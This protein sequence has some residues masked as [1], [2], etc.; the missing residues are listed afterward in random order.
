M[1]ARSTL[2]TDAANRVATAYRST[3]S[4]LRLAGYA[5]AGVATLTS[6][7]PAA[8]NPISLASTMDGESFISEDAATG[9]FGQINRG[10]GTLGGTTSQTDGDI[11]AWYLLSDFNNPNASPAGSQIDM[12]PREADFIVGDIAFDQS[13]VTGSGVE[14]VQITGID[15]SEFWSSDPNRVNSVGGSPATLITDISDRALGLVW[16]DLQGSLTFGGLDAGDTV[17]FTDGLLTSIDL[18]ITAQFNIDTSGFGGPGLTAWDGSFSIVGDQISYQILDTENLGFFASTI[19]ADIT[20]TVN[21]VGTYLIPE[22]A[23][24]ALLAAGLG[25]CLIRRRR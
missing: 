2:T 12:F 10:D 22:P 16:F 20:G 5:V 19:E 24:L 3:L 23:S 11:D 4:S 8:A 7:S 13:S 18:D 14:T 1:P 9:G 21:S 6:G 17:T 15:L 25:A